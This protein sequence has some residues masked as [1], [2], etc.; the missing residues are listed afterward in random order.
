MISRP[1][2]RPRILSS[3]GVSGFYPV[4]ARLRAADAQKPNLI[5]VHIA[6]PSL[7]LSLSLDLLYGRCT[8]PVLAVQSRR[9]R[10]RRTVRHAPRRGYYKFSGSKRR[11][12]SHVEKRRR[13]RE[14]ERERERRSVRTRIIVWNK[15]RHEKG[16]VRLVCRIL[17]TPGSCPRLAAPRVRSCAGQECAYEIRRAPKWLVYPRRTAMPLYRRASGREPRSFF[18][19]CC[20]DTVRCSTR[21][22]TRRGRCE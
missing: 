18:L 22:G 16:E 3:A 20:Y 12:G 15:Y 9:G 4:T 5:V 7:S 14:R 1:R 19:S 10:A 17:K 11:L 21:V 2:E 6:P 8:R 13:E